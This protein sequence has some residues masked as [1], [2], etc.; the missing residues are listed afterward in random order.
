MCWYCSV[1]SFLSNR[2]FQRMYL[3]DVAIREIAD[4][5]RSDKIRCWKKPFATDQPTWGSHPDDRSDRARARPVTNNRIR[6]E[7]LHGRRG[8][9]PGAPIRMPARQLCVWRLESRNSEPR[10]S[11]DE[12]RQSLWGPRRPTNQAR[13]LVAGPTGGWW[14]RACVT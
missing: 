12:L 9:P 4:Q 13:P 2:F 5:I 6:G 3:K 8:T 10:P 7:K 1:R 11:T 14:G